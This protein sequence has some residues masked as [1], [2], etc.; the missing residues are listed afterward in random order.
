MNKI[1]WHYTT[2]NNNNNKS[3]TQIML[4][5]E[6]FCF[7]L[8]FLDSQMVYF[9]RGE[10]GMEGREWIVPNSWSLYSLLFKLIWYLFYSFISPV[11]QSVIII[12]IIVPVVVWVVRQSIY[13]VRYQVSRHVPANTNER[14]NEKKFLF[15]FRLFFIWSFKLELGGD[16][17]VVVD[18]VAVIPPS[19]EFVIVTRDK[20]N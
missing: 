18:V 20:A 3:Q 17:L 5:F 16:F 2:N 4:N 12:I 1:R 8:V 11:I 7:F 9:Y 10:S 14:T 19:A 15:F 6:K 13:T